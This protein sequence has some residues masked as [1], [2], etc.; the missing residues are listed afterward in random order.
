MYL[1]NTLSNH[2]Q[3]TPDKILGLIFNN[4]MSKSEFQYLRTIRW[5]IASL[6]HYIITFVQPK[7]SVFQTLIHGYLIILQ[8]SACNDS[9]ITL[10]CTL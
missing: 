9:Y 8:K 1:K 5:F 7:S 10:F 2:H 3:N 6:I 4:N